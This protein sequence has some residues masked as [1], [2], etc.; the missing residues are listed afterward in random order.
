M[1]LS[2]D[3]RGR[4]LAFSWRM[5]DFAEGQAHEIRIVEPGQSSRLIE[6]T[7]GGGLSEAF[8]A[9]P[10]FD[11]PALFYARAC[12]GDLGGCVG[13]ARITRYDPATRR[14]STQPLA[15]RRTIWFTHT[16]ASAFTLVAPLPTSGTC[17]SDEPSAPGPCELQA[18]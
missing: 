7:R 12:F 13:R 18:G 17:T 11:G 15:S 5:P 14:R 3:L 6:H 8:V 9:W 4:Q 10:V 16:A 1:A 2:L